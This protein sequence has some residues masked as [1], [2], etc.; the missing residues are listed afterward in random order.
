[1][2]TVEL[3][4]ETLETAERLGYHIRQEWLGGTGGGACQF[5]GRRWIFVDL[6]L[7]AVEQLEQVRE[8]L[9]DDPALYSMPLSRAQRRLFGIR[10]AA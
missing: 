5:S 6:A 2:H 10:S 1:M 4:K 9:Q 7:N 8:A 3:L